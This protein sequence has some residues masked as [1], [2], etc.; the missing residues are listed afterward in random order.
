M[1][2]Y[3]IF[4]DK[5]KKEGK[6][7]KKYETKVFYLLPDNIIFIDFLLDNQTIVYWFF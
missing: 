6:K 3:N 7:G 1:Q 2:K 5:Q 4:F